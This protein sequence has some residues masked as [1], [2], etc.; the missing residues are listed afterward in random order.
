[1]PEQSN[2]PQYQLDL[3]RERNPFPGPA[4]VEQIY[5]D[6]SR[7]WMPQEQRR[8]WR[9]IQTGR[10]AAVWDFDNDPAQFP[11]KP[12]PPSVYAIDATPII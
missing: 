10:L 8:K 2:H 6:C 5:D 4:T 7:D 11:K 9:S 3:V 12:L 1:M